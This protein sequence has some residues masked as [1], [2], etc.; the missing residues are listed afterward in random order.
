VT[1]LSTQVIAELVAEV[2]PVWQARQHAKLTDRPRRRALGAG[3]KYKLVFVDRLLVTL[4]HLR[5]ATT[6]DV[7]AAWFDVNRS[8]ITR[9]VNEIRPLLAQRG[10]RIE[11]G[12]RLRTVADVVAY[13]DHVRQT[14]LMDA[15]EIRVR[16]PTKRRAGRHQFIS[17][18]SRSNAMKALVITD[19]QGRLLFCGATCRG[20]TA[21]I[22]QA[23][24]AGVVD[25]LDHT[26]GVEI[27]TDAGYQGLGAQTAGQV[28]TPTQKH[29]KKAVEHM[30][31]IAE[32]RAAQRKT[33][34]QRRVRVEHGIGHV[35]NWRSL[36]RHL[37]RREI[38]D[39]TLRAVAGLLSDHQHTDRPTPSPIAALPAGRA[40]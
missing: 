8:T 20:S 23:R 1:G 29:H 40:K 15:T 34:N 18:K 33:H 7:L 6:H 39:D 5:H 13:L 38:L 31:G 25:W 24:Q 26:G 10:C 27:L 17:G 14:G 21:D 12:V 4:V 2:G 3:A 9:A 35:K 16:R 28:I 22:T 19:A 30:P 11:S 37:G 36:T 32:L